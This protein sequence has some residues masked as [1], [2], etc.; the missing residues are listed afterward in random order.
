MLSQP[1]MQT[2]FPLTHFH[3]SEKKINDLMDGM[4]SSLDKIIRPSHD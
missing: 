1:E 4:V 3:E 2:L